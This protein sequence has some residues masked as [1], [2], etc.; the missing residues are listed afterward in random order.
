MRV[1]PVDLLD[2]AHH[3]LFRIHVED[4]RGGVMGPR[5]GGQSADHR[6]Y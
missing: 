1:R 3:A 2:D 6:G 4:G 5:E